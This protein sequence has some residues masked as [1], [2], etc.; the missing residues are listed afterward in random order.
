M[1]G[2]TDTNGD[3]CDF[4]NYYFC[5]DCGVQWTDYWSCA[6]DDECPNCGHAVSPY[7]WDVDGETHYQ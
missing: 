5:D 3:P 4:T 6:C 2:D 7:A 1:R